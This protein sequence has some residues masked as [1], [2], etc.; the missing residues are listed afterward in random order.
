MV[1]LRGLYYLKAELNEQGEPPWEADPICSNCW[2]VRKIITR[3]QWG[4][5]RKFD[6]PNCKAEFRE[7]YR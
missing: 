7:H 4:R 2:D 3:V 5:P 6:C 1:L